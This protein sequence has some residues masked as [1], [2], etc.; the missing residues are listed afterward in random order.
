M[1][2]FDNERRLYLQK[3][4]KNCRKCFYDNKNDYYY[5]VKSRWVHSEIISK[6]KLDTY[7][8]EEFKNK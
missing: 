3:C 7:S 5:C 2:Y 8:C 4:C 6:E 1:F